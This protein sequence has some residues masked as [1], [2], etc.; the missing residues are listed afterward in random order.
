MCVCVRLTHGRPCGL[1]QL[2]LS[3]L[4]ST[5]VSLLHFPA[6]HPH[7]IHLPPL[8]FVPLLHCSLAPLCSASPSSSSSSSPLQE[9][10]LAVSR[11]AQRTDRHM[12][13]LFCNPPGHTT[14][15][16]VQ[17]WGAG[18]MGSILLPSIYTFPA[19]LRGGLDGIFPLFLADTNA[20]P[21]RNKR[22]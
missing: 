11:L 5:L 16:T 17:G 22:I 20:P 14:L 3:Q 6:P 21:S 13:G 9:L 1:N 8:L 15:A 4:L 10:A 12:G 19:S 2:L 18:L 7:S